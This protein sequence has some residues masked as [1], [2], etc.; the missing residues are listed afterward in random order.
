M[1]TDP[2]ISI[3]GIIRCEDGKATC[4][5]TTYMTLEEALSHLSVDYKLIVVCK[6]ET[7]TSIYHQFVDIGILINYFGVTAT[8]W[9][10]LIHIVSEYYS[11]EGWDKALTYIAVPKAQYY[12]DANATVKTRPTPFE[13]NM[14]DRPNIFSLHHSFQVNGDYVNKKAPAIRSKPSRIKQ[15]PDLVFSKT[16]K[17][18]VS[19]EHTL[20]SIDGNLGYPEYSAQN[21]ELFIKNGAHFLRGTENPDQNIVFTDFYHM[22]PEGYK[23]QSVYF[24]DCAPELFLQQGDHIEL[25]SNDNG[26]V[27]TLLNRDIAFWKQSHITLK[28]AV[29]FT[30]HA[31]HRSNYIP[32]ICFGGKLFLPGLDDITSYRIEVDDQSYLVVQFIVDLDLLVRIASVNLQHAGIFLGASSIYHVAIGYLLSNVFT[33]KE[34]NIPHSSEEWRALEYVRKSDIPFVSIITTD[35]LYDVARIDPIVDMHDGDLKFPANSRGLLINGLTR[36]IVDYTRVD[37]AESTM[38]TTTPEKPLFVSKPEGPAPHMN[39]M[40]KNATGTKLVEDTSRIVQTISLGSDIYT[41]FPPDAVIKFSLVEGVRYVVRSASNFVVYGKSNPEPFE[42]DDASNY[43]SYSWDSI[44]AVEADV[45]WDAV[46]GA[47]CV[48][49]DDVIYVAQNAFNGASHKAVTSLT[50]R[51]VLPVTNRTITWFIYETLLEIPDGMRYNNVIWQ[52]DPVLYKDSHNRY[53]AGEQLKDTSKYFLLDFVY[54]GENSDLGLVPAGPENEG[55][56][57]DP[58][59]TVEYEAIRARLKEL[60]PGAGTIVTVSKTFEANNGTYHS[61]DITLEVSNLSDSNYDGRYQKFP[62]GITW[63]KDPVKLTYVDNRWT[64]FIPSWFDPIAGV[65]H[66]T[67]LLAASNEVASSTKPYDHSV[68]WRNVNG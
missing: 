38:I 43:I 33:T 30:P 14:R 17:S 68:I 66:D 4:F 15:M 59:L 13:S 21:D 34:Y 29:P 49:V 11:Q 3:V 35:Y 64:L 7:G 52:K 39:N 50:W 31:E 40:I 42:R 63:V 26:V 32:L 62:D 51:K 54:A 53:F 22:F 46:N 1:P 57:E 10:D 19:F 45:E 27:D 25:Y 56:A 18:E 20:V 12:R 61:T 58:V 9:D 8:N 67:V 6:I 23:L 5:D 41:F 37:Y 48:S 16:D 36:E 2:S 55:N 60:K 24:S 28:F 65:I 47:A 44:G